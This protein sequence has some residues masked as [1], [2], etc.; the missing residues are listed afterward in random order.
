MTLVRLVQES[1]V[2]DACPLCGV[3]LGQPNRITRRQIVLTLRPGVFCWR[4]PDCTG[5]WAVRGVRHS[6]GE[7]LPPRA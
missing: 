1:S 3:T 5:T 2:G 7:D 6:A 4:C